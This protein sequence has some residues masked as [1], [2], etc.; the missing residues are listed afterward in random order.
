M[1][2][3]SIITS[4]ALLAAGISA[5]AQQTTTPTSGQDGHNPHTTVKRERVLPLVTTKIKLLTRAYGDSIVL[6]WAAEDYVSWKYLA[7]FGVNVLRVPKDSTLRGL[8]IDTLAYALKPLTLEQFQAKYPTTDSLALVPQGVLYG[9]AEN[10]HW[11]QEGTMGRTLEDNSN[12]DLSFGFAML[13]AEWRRDLATDMAVRLVDR[14]AEAGKTYD[15]YVQPTRWENDGHLIFEPGVAE[16]VKNVPYVP[17]AYT[18]RMVDS[19]STPHT[20]TIGWWDAEHSSFEI[21]RRQVSDLMGRSR[22]TDWQ[23]VN[24]KPYV[25]MVEQPEGEDY[26][27]FGDSVPELGVWEYRIRA[28]DA[29]GDLTEPS[30]ERRIV[31]RDVQP[32]TAPTLKYVVL[33]RPE[34]DPMAKVIANIVWEKP[35]KE[36]DLAGYRIYYNPMRGDGGAWRPLNIDMISP[37]DTLYTVDVTGL[38]TGMVYIAAIDDSG[39]EARSFTQQLRL[40]DYKAPDPPQNLRATVMPID[41]DSLKAH[42]D[43]KVEVVLSWSPCPDDDLA[44]Y[45]LAAAND[46][47]H[48]FVNV[49]QM[50]IRENVYTD[51]LVLD[52]NQKYIYYRV[53]ATDISSNIGLWSRWIEVE[54]PHLSPPTTAHIHSS[55]QDDKTGIHMEWV[56]GADADMKYHSLYR[57]AGEGGKWKRIGRYDADSLRAHDNM[58]IV[59]DNPPYLQTERYYYFVQSTNASPFKSQS[60][61]VSF[62]H[63][64]P[65]NLDIPI[66][67]YA[68]Y[69][70]RQ[71]ETRLA[72]EVDEKLLPSDG[73]G[74]FCIYRKGPGEDEFTYLRNVELTERSYSDHQMRPSDT[75]QQAEYYI[76]VQYADGRSSQDSNTVTVKAPAKK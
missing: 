24:T 57:R 4:I 70:E 20:L 17:Q 56:V 62:R 28:Y 18:P 7:D 9:E 8:Q 42:K 14:T 32:P 36:P 73:R 10:L 61:A 55:S 50:G 64:G 44:Y 48:E 66:K 40:Q 53:R 27:L 63:R 25:S 31:V 74:Y 75:E 15:Y 47:T 59:D 26:C 33:E 12:Q 76:H 34:E 5:G 30:P 39:N 67:L 11:E 29:F 65:R 35:D 68:S 49:N 72:W 16:D 52:V 71:G 2:Y 13:V 6:R 51:T 46:S 54:R 58:I 3:K 69:L 37:A 22:E 19:L 1:N 38:S 23:R 60:L 41:L 45:D 43:L 21:D